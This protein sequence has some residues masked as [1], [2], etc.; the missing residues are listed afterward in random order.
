MA[1]LDRIVELWNVGDFG[2][3]AVKAEA[4]RGHTRLYVDH[5]C[6]ASIPHQIVV[7]PESPE[8][9]LRV[10]ERKCRHA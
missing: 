4:Y 7:R 8:F 2:F 5:S 1:T 6:P 3:K 9:L 10:L